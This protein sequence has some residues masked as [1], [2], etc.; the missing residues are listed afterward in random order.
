MASSAKY[1]EQ[2]VGNEL[3]SVGKSHAIDINKYNEESEM[4]IAENTRERRDLKK[5]KGKSKYKSSGRISVGTWSKTKQ[6]NKN[7]K[8]KKE[9]KEKKNRKVKK[10]MKER[11]NRKVK[12]AKKERKV[13]KI[14]KNRKMKNDR[15]GKGKKIKVTKGRER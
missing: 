12:K 6:N 13:K 14:N 2:N 9:I 10:G 8:V 15:K 4:E 5:K 11:K 3:T 1:E 7:R